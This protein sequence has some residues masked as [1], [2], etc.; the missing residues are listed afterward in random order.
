VATGIPSMLPGAQ[1]FASPLRIDDK[2]RPQPYLAERFELSQDNRSVTLQL[3]RE[4]KFHD[5]RPITSE[6]VQFSFEMLREHH[7]FKSMFAPVNAV[8][9]SDRHTAVVR[10]SEPHPA[11]LL[12]MTSSMCPIMPKHIYGD[13]APML[14]HPRNTQRVVGS[15][16]FRLVEFK[17]PEHIVMER[18]DGFFIKDRPLLDRLVVRFFKE[19]QTMLLAVERGEIDYSVQVDTRD[20]ERASKS[21]S[22]VLVKDVGPALGAL[23]WISMNTRH[24][25]LQDRRVRQAINYAI[26][27][28]FIIRSL[29]SGV[30]HRATGPISRGSPFYE[31]SV[32]RY[33]FDLRKAAQL[34]DEA[35]LKPGAD[36]VRTT[37]TVD[38][39][40]ANAEHRT[41]QEFLRPALAKVGIA[42]NV[43]ISPDSATWVRRISSH[44]FDLNVEG[45]FNWGDPVIGVH[46]SW[47]SSN[48]RK[49]VMFSNTHQYSNPAVDEL[50]TAAGKE[51]DTAKRKALY[52]RLQKV[53][54]EDSPAIFVAE[55]N[56]HAAMSPRVVNA[57]NNV[58]GALSQWDET[59]LRRG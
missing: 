51:M 50:C 32:Q 29:F 8:T 49:G 28:D 38:G 36:G 33:D 52:S 39:T 24:P 59:S 6:D 34:L 48:I 44:E 23:T 37:L 19:P 16:P 53:V 47:I 22:M 11:L 3:R 12:A 10:L 55:A 21:K 4:A 56:W 45:V 58:W 35:G 13:G 30:P 43:R 27:K 54:V 5:G 15:G 18:F 42:V 41:I 14:T 20:V 46:R 7:P 1:L 26:D 25:Q 31:A 9:L 17:P 57:P 2:W 40:P